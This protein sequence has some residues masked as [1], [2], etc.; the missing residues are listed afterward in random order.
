ME[1]KKENNRVNLFIDSR[2][3]GFATFPSIDENIV[4]I[5]HTIVYPQYQNKGYASKLLYAIVEVL[6]ETNRKC[7]VSCSYAASWFLKHP[8][9]S[10]LLDD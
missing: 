7:R 1:I 5:N 10:F 3:A 6:E 2:L 9:Y 4:V 8:E